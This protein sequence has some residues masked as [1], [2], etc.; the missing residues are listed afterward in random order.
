MLYFILL[1]KGKICYNTGNISQCGMGLF[2]NM[3]VNMQR[4]PNFNFE[5]Y[6]SHHTVGVFLSMTLPS[7]EGFSHQSEC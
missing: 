1:N 3:L 7:M 5:K 6:S 2:F 4:F